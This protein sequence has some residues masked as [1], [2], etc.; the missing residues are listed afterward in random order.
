MIKCIIV[1]DEPNAIDVLKDWATQGC[2]IAI[3]TGR[4]TATYEP[5]LNWLDKHDVPYHSFTMVDKYSRESGDKSIAISLEDL[6]DM[7][8]SL[9]VE[10]S[11]SMAQHISQQMGIPVALV[12]RPWN[13]TADLN[14]KINRY[15]SWQH[16]QKDFPN[17]LSLGT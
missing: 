12:D 15:T 3:V 10:D 9:A 5:S 17:P 1:E 13:R 6:S 11:A 4:P 16:I 14:A 7:D 8:F 2:H